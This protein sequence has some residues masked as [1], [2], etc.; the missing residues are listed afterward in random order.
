MTGVR[1]HA[2]SDGAA[3]VTDAPSTP[4]PRVL[5][6][7]ATFR[8]VNNQAVGF[9]NDLSDYPYAV[10]TT[11][12]SGEPFID[13]RD[14]RRE[15]RRRRSTRRCP[16]VSL[17]RPA[18]LPDRVDAD[19]RSSYY[20]DGALVATHAMRDRPGQMRPVISDYGLFGA[21]MK[22]DWLRMSPYATT[23][24]FTSRVLDSGPG[25]ND[26]AH[27]DAAQRR[28]RPARGSRSRRAPA[29][30]ATPDATLVGLAGVG[31]SSA[32]ASPNVALH[33]V[34][35]DADRH[36][37]GV[38]ADRS[39]RVTVAF[40][41]GTDHAPNAGHRHALAGRAEDQPDRHGDAERLQRPGRR[42]AHLP[43]RVVPQ[44]HR[45]RGRDDAH[46]RTSHW[47]A[48][49]TAA[50]RSAPR[51]TR[52]TAAARRAT[53]PPPGHRRQHRADRAA[54]CRSRRRPPSTKD[55]VRGQRVA[56]SPTSTATR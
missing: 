4:G 43:L 49:A 1:R 19:A 11:G 22:V 2:V 47:P 20:V 54:P 37:H 42:P 55:V 17:E 50:T 15:P 48:T 51:S 23:G 7:T 12:G 30:R 9:G 28:C 36:R 38:D 14:E 45:D 3:I 10:F 8:P 56:A 18:P 34:P 53:P 21:A 5:E 6:F 24:T 35:R 29:P 31:A 16:N 32:I 26:W 25:A 52:P 41:A 13:V 40:G 39:Q 27:A 44:R 33:P 46:A